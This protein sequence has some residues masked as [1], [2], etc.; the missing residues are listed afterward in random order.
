MNIP[1][2]KDV[3]LVGGI[4]LMVDALTSLQYVHDKRWFCYLSSNFGGK[5]IVGIFGS[6]ASRAKNGNRR[7]DICHSLKTFDKLCQNTKDFPRIQLRVVICHNSNLF[8]GVFMKI[9]SKQEIKT[10]KI[11]VNLIL[12]KE[13]VK[14]LIDGKVINGEDSHLAIQIVGYG[15][16]EAEANKA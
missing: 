12:T 11:F 6:E 16:E 1:I 10:G 8:G 5:R 9:M 7:S 2:V 3:L 14:R 4:A 13:E 15:E